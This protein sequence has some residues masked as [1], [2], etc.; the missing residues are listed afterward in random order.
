MTQLA[1]VAQRLALE[2]A[3]RAQ[4]TSGGALQGIV[5]LTT[6]EQAALSALRLPL[7]QTTRQLKDRLLK[8]FVPDMG[9]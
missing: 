8:G 5:G 3:F 9:W 6:E 4:V 7:T 2:P 1:T